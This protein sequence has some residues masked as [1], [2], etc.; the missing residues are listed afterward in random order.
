ML[1]FVEFLTELGEEESGWERRK[2]PQKEV[3]ATIRSFRVGDRLTRRQVH[4]RH[5]LG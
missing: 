2:R 1:W 5:A 4:D 3:L